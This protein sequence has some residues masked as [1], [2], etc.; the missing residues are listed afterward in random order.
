MTGEIHP[1]LTKEETAHIANVIWEGLQAP[2][3][4]RNDLIDFGKSV[5]AKVSLKDMDAKLYE[6][7]APH[8]IC[9]T[10]NMMARAKPLLGGTKAPEEVT[11]DELRAG[12]NI[13]WG[14]LTTPK[15]TPDIL[16]E[17]GKCTFAKTPLRSMDNKL[18]SKLL[19]FILE[20]GASFGNQVKTLFASEPASSESKTVEKAPVENT[21]VP[22]ST[23]PETEK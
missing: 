5:H 10:R 20:I 13:I 23:P 2:P 8:I 17:L 1:E 3:W 21:D 22:E 11:Q 6:R 7:L 9:A 12:I 15:W 14:A 18:F 19:P 16:I 4:L